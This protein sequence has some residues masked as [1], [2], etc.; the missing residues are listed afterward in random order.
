MSSKEVANIP[1]FYPFKGQ[2]PKSIVE[3]A[4]EYW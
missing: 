4:S 3:P 1:G 2:Y